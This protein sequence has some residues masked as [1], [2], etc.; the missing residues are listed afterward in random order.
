[1]RPSVPEWPYPT[2]GLRPN[3]PEW[4]NTTPEQDYETNR[5]ASER[6]GDERNVERQAGS[7]E[8]LTGHAPNE[9]RVRSVPAGNDTFSSIRRGRE[10]VGCSCQLELEVA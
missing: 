10:P 5:Q 8:G 3:V 6:K 4:L 2:R 7:Q 9:D 1:M